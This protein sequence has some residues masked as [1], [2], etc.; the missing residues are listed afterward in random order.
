MIRTMPNDKNWRNGEPDEVE[1]EW[2]ILQ[3]DYNKADGGPND[4]LAAAPE[5]LPDGDEVVT[6]RYEFYKYIGPL[7]DE[8]GEAMADNRWVPDGIHGDGIKTHQR[9]GGGSLRP[10]RSWANSPARKWPPWMWMRRSA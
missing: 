6:R 2:Q 1:I 4:E 10:W 3:K 9:R 7:D 5:D 8:T